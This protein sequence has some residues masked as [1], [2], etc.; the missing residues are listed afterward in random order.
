[1]TEMKS[2]HDVIDDFDNQSLL[3][4]LRS[5]MFQEAYEEYLME[6]GTLSEVER[7]CMLHARVAIISNGEI[8]RFDVLELPKNW[9]R[10][11]E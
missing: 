7:Y 8:I 11:E 10:R 2:I 4:T 5:K 1:M 9:W 6:A 3:R